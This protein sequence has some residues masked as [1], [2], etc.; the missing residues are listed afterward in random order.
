MY[1]GV[2]KTNFPGIATYY[3]T[4]LVQSNYRKLPRVLYVTIMA[5]NAQS[6]HSLYADSNGDRGAREVLH[7]NSPVQRCITLG[8]L[9]MSI[10]ITY[11]KDS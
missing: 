5:F 1:V 6:T 2:V 7:N 11:G 4:I 10:E 3:T 8:T 9:K